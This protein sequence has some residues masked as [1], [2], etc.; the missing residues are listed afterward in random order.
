MTAKKTLSIAP[1]PS[2]EQSSELPAG[3]T[4]F[5]VIAALQDAADEYFCED[6]DAADLAVC[7]SLVELR[8]RLSADN[9][10][11]SDKD[12]PLAA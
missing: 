4:L 5:D 10:S 2:T 1:N 11:Q 7:A 9:A 8:N 12:L 3:T 6:A